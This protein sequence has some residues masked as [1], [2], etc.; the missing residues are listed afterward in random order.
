MRQIMKGELALVVDGNNSSS[1][2]CKGKNTR[3]FSQE[4]LKGL[5]TLVTDT[6]S[7]TAD[8]LCARDGNVALTGWNDNQKDHFG[9]AL[10]RDDLLCCA[11]VRSRKGE[12]PSLAAVEELREIVSFV[13]SSSTTNDLSREDTNDESSST[14]ELPRGCDANTTTRPTLQ[15]SS[16]FQETRRTEQCAPNGHA[17]ELM[18]TTSG[19]LQFSVKSANDVEYE[20]TG[21]PFDLGHDFSTSSGEDADY[22]V[23]MGE[24]EADSKACCAMSEEEGESSLDHVLGNPFAGKEESSEDNSD[25]KTAGLW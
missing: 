16:G 5:F 23:R 4:E 19:A 17:S 15:Q 2:A 3:H 14:N 12:L 24:V 6:C 25:D 9:S 21:D 1:T 13:H 22:A 11:C 10:Q 7:E 18:V 8:L 20:E